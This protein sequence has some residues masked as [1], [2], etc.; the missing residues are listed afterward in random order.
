ME[1]ILNLTQHAATKEQLE[2]GVIEPEDKA[3]VQGLLTFDSLPSPKEIQ[4]RANALAKIAKEA[5]VEAVMIGGAPYLMGP[6]E[7]ALRLEGITP[8]Y[9]YSKRVSVDEPQ[10]DGSVIKKMVFRHEGFIEGAL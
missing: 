8:L 3:R 7:I 4:E 1:K 9:A 10:A 5:G 2:A 6:L